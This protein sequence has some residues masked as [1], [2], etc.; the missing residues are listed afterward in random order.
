ME[1]FQRDEGLS[2]HPDLCFNEGVYHE[3]YVVTLLPQPQSQQDPGRKNWNIPSRQGSSVLC[4]DINCSTEQVAS[5]D[6]KTLVDGTTEISVSHPGASTPFFKASVKSI[7][8]ISS[9]SIRSST[10][11]LGKY[12]TLIQPPLPAGDESEEVATSQWASL[13]PVLA[14]STSLRTM[15]PGLAGKVGDGAG[16]PAVAPWSIAFAM[17]NL[18]M[19]FGT[20]TL[21]DAI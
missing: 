16:F 21:H 17:E 15:T 5:F 20:P 3:R 19:E 6:I 18:D 7:P 13:T 9:L 2:H 11:I 14:G 4:L 1:T 8:V 12:F 10:S